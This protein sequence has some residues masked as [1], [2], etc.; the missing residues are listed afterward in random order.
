[1]NWINKQKLPAVETIKYEGQLCLTPES[2]WRAF[3][4]TFNTAL[5]HQV[6]TDVLNEIGSKTTAAWVLFSKEEFRQALIKCNNSSASGP[7]KLMWRHLKTIL[8]QNVY[9][10]CIINIADVC[11]DLGY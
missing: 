6:D 9:L 10:S 8:K 5:Y 4:A 7:N 11:I 3:H 2:L 1:M